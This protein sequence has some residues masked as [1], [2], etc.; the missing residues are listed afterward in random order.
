[1]VLLT[2]AA[3]EALVRTMDAIAVPG[4]AFAKTA[5]LFLLAA[6]LLIDSFRRSAAR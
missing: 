6:V 2:V 4:R 3:G 1:M 5:G